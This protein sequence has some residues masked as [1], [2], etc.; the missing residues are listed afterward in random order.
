MSFHRLIYSRTWINL[1]FLLFHYQKRCTSGWTLSGLYASV[2]RY[3]DRI[4][5]KFQHV[6]RSQENPTTELVFEKS[7]G[8][9]PITMSCYRV[10]V[11]I[12]VH[13][14]RV[15]DIPH[16]YSNSICLICYRYHSSFAMN[17]NLNIE[18]VSIRCSS[19]QIQIVCFLLE[20]TVLFARGITEIRP[21]IYHL[22]NRWNITP[23]GLTISFYVVA[24]KIVSILWLCENLNLA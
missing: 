7:Y 24:E 8:N 14:N 20:G 23:I 15:I 22:F 3:F 5:S 2:I 19:I 13:D 11:R 18:P 12:H 4:W 6:A 1:L 10:H 9:S 21:K 17:K 16:P